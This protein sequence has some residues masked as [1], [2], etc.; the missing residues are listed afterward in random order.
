MTCAIIKARDSDEEKSGFFARILAG[1]R[2]GSISN[3]EMPYASE[4]VFVYTLPHSK[5]EIESLPPAKRLKLWIKSARELLAQQVKYLYV[6][7]ELTGL[8]ANEIWDKYFDIPDG[9]L[10]FQSLIPHILRK[11]VGQKGI[12]PMEMEVGIW[13]KTFD[14][15]GYNVLLGIV[16]F[17]KFITL[18]TPNPQ[19]AERHINDIY[20]QTG[21]SINV[22][23]NV[24]DISKCD[25][26]VALSDLPYMAGDRE[27]LVIDGTKEYTGT[28]GACINTLQFSVPFGFSVLGN[29]LDKF[30]ERSMEFLLYVCN[31]AAGQGGDI[32]GAIEKIGC[33]IRSTSYDKNKQKEK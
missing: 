19:L 11:S 31:K 13:Q 29:L 9:T 21:L 3:I 30:D 7:Q 27:V 6:P 1:I 18:F 25:A 28:N 12:D 22:S 15:N 5:S 33:K 20:V 17:V 8:G 10:V 16:D 14:N 2:K 32:A 23:A 24:K 26:V 4:G